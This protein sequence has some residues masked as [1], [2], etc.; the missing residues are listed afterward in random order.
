[1]MWKIPTSAM[2]SKGLDVHGRPLDFLAAPTTPAT[3]TTPTTPQPVPTLVSKTSKTSPFNLS[4]LC[5]PENIPYTDTH[6]AMAGYF[7]MERMMIIQWVDRVGVTKASPIGYGNSG[8]N[9]PLDHP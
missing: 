1:M 7:I 4:H 5:V 2:V 8:L 6:L 9:R 3:P